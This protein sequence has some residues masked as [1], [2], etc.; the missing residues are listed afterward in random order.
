MKLGG[1]IGLPSTHSGWL[2]LSLQ[3]YSWFTNKVKSAEA[4]SYIGT[5]LVVGVAF[6]LLY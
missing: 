5:Y 2:L 1:G 4:G 3:H 6:V